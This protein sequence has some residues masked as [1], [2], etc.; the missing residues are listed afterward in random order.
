LVA[1]FLPDPIPAFTSGTVPIFA[2]VA[3]VVVS[4]SAPRASPRHRRRRPLRRLF[5]LASSALI[6]DRPFGN[7]AG[8]ALSV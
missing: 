2:S 5:A 8:T 6:S 7:Q 4:P 1:S 3:G